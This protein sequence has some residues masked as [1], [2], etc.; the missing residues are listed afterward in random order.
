MNESSV[1][2]TDR[3]S[4]LE[5]P[6]VPGQ[7]PSTADL[8]ELLNRLNQIMSHLPPGGVEEEDPPEYEG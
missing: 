8:P 3:D 1:I 2:S 5:S 4:E 7:P 6:S